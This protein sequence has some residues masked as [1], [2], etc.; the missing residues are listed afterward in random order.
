MKLLT[1]I[2][3][4]TGLAVVTIQFIQPARNRDERAFESDISKVMSIPDSVQ[5]ILK[6]ACF[7]CHSNNTVYPWYSNIQPV[8]WFLA[9][10]IK[11]AKEN[12]NFSEFGTYNQRR[13]L[14]KLN[15]IADEI[16]ENAMP[17]PSYRLMHKDARLLPEEKR[18]LI[19]WAENS[20][21]G[22]TEE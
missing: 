3:L 13:R 12:L 15:A 16:N 1:K 20:T 9:R 21:A 17:L 19:S 11:L 10:D 7:D 5:T 8:G 18:L 14:S 22:A 6:N 2:L 4:A